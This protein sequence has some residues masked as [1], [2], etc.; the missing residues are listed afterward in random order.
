MTGTAIL[1]ALLLVVAG[2]ALSVQAPINAGLAKAIGGSVPAAAISF[3]V[4]CI[5]LTVI[6]LLA[7]QG[8]S[9]LQLGQVS[10]WQFVGGAL[11]ALYVWAAIW[12]VGSL[13]VV[14]MIAAVIL[15]QLLG[16]MTVDTLGAF[17]V[18]V[19]ELSVTRVLAVAM[20][21]GGLVLSRV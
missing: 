5:V 13:G 17:G 10:G 21:G 8:G 14:T 11:G 9:F 3:G 15:G 2:V 4:G 16:A 6:A 1:A 20:V 12:S 19:R 7:R 18:P